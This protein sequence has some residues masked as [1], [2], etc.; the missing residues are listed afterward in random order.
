MM[1]TAPALLETFRDPAGSLRIE[2]DRVLRHVKP[3]HASETIRFLQSDLARKWVADGRLIS[4]EIADRADRGDLFL[5]HPRIFFP[6]YPWEWTPGAWMAAAELTLDLCEALLDQGLILKDA[7]PLNV[8]FDGARPV[9]VDVLSIEKRD[10][11]SPLWLAYGQFVRTFLLPLAAYRYLGWPLAASLQKRDGYEPSD[12]YPWLSRMRRWGQPLRSLVTLPYLLERRN[13][14]KATAGSKLRQAPEVAAAV[15]RR[16]LHVL[17]SRLKKLTPE[18]RESRWSSYPNSAGHYSETDHEQ[19]QQFIRE[20]LSLAHP[21]KV[22]D[23]GANTG[24]YSRIAAEQGATVIGWDTDAEATE[25]NWREARS[26]KLDILPLIADPARP[27]PA[28][29]WRNAENLSLLH[30]AQGRFDCVMV[31]GFI[32]HLLLAEQIPLGEVAGL[33][34][35]LTTAWTIVE[36]VPATDPRFEELVRGRDALY[37]HL[38]ENAFVQAIDPYFSCMLRKELAN[39]RALFLLRAR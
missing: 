11:E 3:G 8:L 26:R 30:R 32:H 21:K 13:T 20:A 17:R 35:E 16:N 18:S 27:T 15:L 2:G 22:L 37:A 29:G 38:D 12:L 14:G 6:S 33:L 24:V 34:R 5:E 1:A 9:F 39:G 10:P 7:T 23:L 25:H 31:L 4:T 36:W 28:T 19:K